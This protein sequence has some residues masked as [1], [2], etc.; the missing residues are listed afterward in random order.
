MPRN[1]SR[2]SSL[3]KLETLPDVTVVGAG[4]LGS[5]IALTL[6]QM[7]I[8]EGVSN[9]VVY[10]P[11]RVEE[12][13]QPASF[14]YVDDYGSAKVDALQD[15]IDLMNGVQIATAETL[16]QGQTVSTVMVLAV[17]SLQARREI[18]DAILD[19]VN[20]LIDARSGKNLVEVYTFRNGDDPSFYL[21]SLKEGE[22]VVQ[23]RCSERAVAYNAMTVAGIVG[24][25]VASF[26]RGERERIPA[27]VVVDHGN[28]IML[29]E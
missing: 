18:V 15:N 5:W 29:V 22:D 3:V 8:G 28:W 23:L 11:D 20:L 27:H 14:Y 2:Q 24:G 19:K 17:D 25:M 12:A 10:D 21:A 9:L 7:G 4:H 13:N 6:T 16:Y 26:T 1:F